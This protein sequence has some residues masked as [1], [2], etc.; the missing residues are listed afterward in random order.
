MENERKS[1]RA[2]ALIRQGSRFTAIAIA[3]AIATSP[4]FDNHKLMP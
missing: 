2:V 1:S 4:H 3:I